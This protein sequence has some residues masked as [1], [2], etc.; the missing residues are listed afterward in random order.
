MKKSHSNLWY[1]SFTDNTIRFWDDEEE[2]TEETPR[3]L[4]E[5]LWSAP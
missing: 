1:L 3:T 2:I 4:G 5:R